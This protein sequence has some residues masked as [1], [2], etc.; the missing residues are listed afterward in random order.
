[1][2]RARHRAGAHASCCESSCAPAICERNDTRPLLNLPIPAAQNMLCNGLSSSPSLVGKALP[3][4]S[5]ADNVRLQKALLDSLGVTKLALVY[6]WSSAC[7]RCTRSFR[8]SFRRPSCPPFVH[9]PHK[10]IL[11]SISH[12]FSLVGAT[13]AIH[14]AVMYPS[15]VER[16]L[17]SCGTASCGALN[18]VFLDGLAAV[19]TRCDAFSAHGGFFPVQPTAALDAFGRV[20]AGWCLSDEFF[21]SEMWRSLGCSSVEEFLKNYCSAWATERDANDFL[22]Q[23]ATWR[24]SDVT[25]AAAAVGDA[26]G[27]GSRVSALGRVSARVLVCASGGDRIFSLRQARAEAAAMGP[28]ERVEV[29]LL[30][31]AYGHFSG[32]PW[33]AGQEADAAALRAAVAR[34]LDH[35]A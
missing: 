26:V 31:E 25:H 13:Q 10:H 30:S 15:F 16:V 12:P 22:A 11:I 33:M 2:S 9:L 24:H 29:V 17:A 20:D 4:I 5:V 34:L 3:L 28:P 32:N 6:G 18:A 1:M 8:A 7:C 27:A 21:E 35:W 19:L 23:I 14:W